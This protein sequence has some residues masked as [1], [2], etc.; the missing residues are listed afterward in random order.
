VAAVTEPTTVVPDLSS[1][2]R[3]ILVMIAGGMSNLDIGARLFLTEDTVKTHIRR[4]YKLLGVTTRAEAVG[5]AYRS[6]LLAVDAPV[7][8]PSRP[9]PAAPPVPAVAPAPAPPTAPKPARTGQARASRPVVAITHRMLSA[10]RSAVHTGNTLVIIRVVLEASGLGV[11]RHRDG[12]E[13]AT[14]AVTA[15]RPLIV[16]TDRMLA[17]VRGAVATRDPLVITRCVLEQ[18]GITAVRAG[19]S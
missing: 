16:V 7:P 2:Q 11:T 15:R 12:E 13:L 1:R 3:E 4:M 5:V 8:P 17:V 10:V 18:A 6:G 9:D 19:T 14:A